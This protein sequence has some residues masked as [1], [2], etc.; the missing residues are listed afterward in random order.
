MTDTDPHGL[1]HAA[2]EASRH[3][4]RQ[5]LLLSRV[6]LVSA[7]VAAIGGAFKWKIGGGYDVWVFV[8][9][10]GFFVALFAEVLL[11]TTQPGQQW[12]AGRA[13]TEQIKSLIWP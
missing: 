8:A 9:L 6:R 4:Q 3:D 2:D 1:Y 11:W 13:V 12:N 7:V 5:T 10:T